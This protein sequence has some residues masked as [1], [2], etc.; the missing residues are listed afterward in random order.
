MTEQTAAFRHKTFYRKLD[1][2]L[3]QID[4]EQG[5]ESML[6][7]ILS[8]VAEHVIGEEGPLN[9]GRLYRRDGG[10]FVIVRSFGARG[11]ERGR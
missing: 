9:S 4:E 11:K 1:D 10:D 2:I 6:T 8:R 5:L 3:R 7:A